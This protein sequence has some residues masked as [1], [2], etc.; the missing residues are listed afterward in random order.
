MSVN[1]T[2]HQINSTDIARLAG[3]S[4]ATVSRVLSEWARISAAK[5]SQVMKVVDELGYRPNPFA[6]AMR[7]WQSGV[8][9]VAVSRIP[10][11]VVPEILEALFAELTALRRRMLVWNTDTEGTFGV[12][13]AT[14][15]GMI[16]G[17]IFTAA[18]HQSHSMGAALDDGFPVVSLN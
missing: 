10:N 15:Q 18:S 5:Y 3:V 4:Q 9:G 6:Q 14:R 17:M 8:V 11:P 2:S 12:I 16:D 1:K 7:T 13:E